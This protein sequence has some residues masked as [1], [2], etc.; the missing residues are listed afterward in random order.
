MNLC[1]IHRDYKSKWQTPCIICRL[2]N[3]IKELSREINQLERRA[4]HITSENSPHT[5]SYDSLADNSI[6][7]RPKYTPF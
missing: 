1:E 2:E 4:G 3:R 6:K 5:T 7:D